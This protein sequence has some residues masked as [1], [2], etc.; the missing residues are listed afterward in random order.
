MELLIWQYSIS[1]ETPMG[2]SIIVL[3]GVCDVESENHWG[4]SIMYLSGAC[5]IRKEWK[6][7]TK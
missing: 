6:T 4:Y 3:S 5:D 2:Y 1:K 7:R